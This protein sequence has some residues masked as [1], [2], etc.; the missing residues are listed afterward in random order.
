[1]INRLDQL[2]SPMEDRDFFASREQEQQPDIRLIF[3][4]LPEP[5]GI[6]N[7]L[8]EPILPD[9]LIPVS[10]VGISAVLRPE[11]EQIISELVGAGLQ[12]KIL[13][14]DAPKEAER[15][16][17]ELGLPGDRM[18]LVSGNDLEELDGEAF[19]ST[20]HE[21]NVLGDLTPVQKASIVEKLR[22]AGENVVMLGNSVQD[23]PAMKVANLKIALRNSTQTALRLT[24]I[25][26]LKNSLS[27]LPLV[28]STG[29]RLVNGILDLFKLYLSQT[30]AQMLLVL[31]I[32]VVG[33]FDFPYHPTQAGIISLFT[34]AIPGIFLSVWSAAGRVSG[35]SM[36]R[37]LTKFIIPSA[38]TLA[39]LTW[40][41]YLFFLSRYQS[42]D[43]AQVVVTYALLLAGW[44][45]VLFVQ[46]PASFW[47]GGAPL[48]GDRRVVIVVLGSVLLFLLIITIP[49]FQE[50][51]RM[52][53]LQSA[54]DY[55]IVILVVAIWALIT[56]AIWRSNWLEQLINKI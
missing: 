51:M 6:I 21:G 15:T 2:L 55:L 10:R 7:H 9:N 29:Q 4:Y 30:F 18:V 56:R 47:T 22:S 42:E 23:V 19:T 39:I 5:V 26:L 20:I 16:A 44:L 49:F 31:S 43:Y 13:S 36:R 52:A 25:V 46:P 38:L 27:A 41:V 40:G 14:A 24:D 45:R 28:I 54:L 8:G 48:R 17:L 34:V 32:L 37:Q 11:G 1:M 33:Y 50:I 53:W 35:T 12:V 3:A